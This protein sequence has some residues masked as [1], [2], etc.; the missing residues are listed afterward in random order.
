MMPKEGFGFSR[1]AK[2]RMGP[3]SFQDAVFPVGAANE[4]LTIRMRYML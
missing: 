2:V 4:K 1:D 3:P